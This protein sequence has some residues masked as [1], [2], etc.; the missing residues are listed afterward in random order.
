METPTCALEAYLGS[1][2]QLESSCFCVFG[3]FQ[4][5]KA[6][7][8]FD[9]SRFVSRVGIGLAAIFDLLSFDNDKKA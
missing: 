4:M 7:K 9:H 1:G 5:Q 2:C 8:L 6:R 3:M